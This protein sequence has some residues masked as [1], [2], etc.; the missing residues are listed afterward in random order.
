MKSWLVLVILSFLCIALWF[1]PGPARLSDDSAPTER[2]KV[3]EVDN[4]SLQVHGLV[5]FGTQRLKVLCRDGKIT[6]NGTEYKGE[7]LEL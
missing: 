5:E 4:A 1:V 3:V 6:V 2:A 7:G